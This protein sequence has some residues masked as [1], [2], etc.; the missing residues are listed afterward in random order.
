MSSCSEENARLKKE[1]QN[2]LDMLKWTKDRLIEAEIEL[3][4]ANWRI[5]ALLEGRNDEAYS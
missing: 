4:R 2:A 5:T 3:R 1:L